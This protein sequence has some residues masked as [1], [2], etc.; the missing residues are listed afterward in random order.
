MCLLGFSTAFCFTW[1]F[2]HFFF[3]QYWVAGL[4]G[5]ISRWTLGWTGHVDKNSCQGICGQVMSSPAHPRLISS[6]AS[7]VL[8]GEVQEQPSLVEAGAQTCTS[9][10]T[11]QK[12]HQ[13]LSGSSTTQLQALPKIDAKSGSRHFVPWQLLDF[14][15]TFHFM[16]CLHISECLGCFCTRITHPYTQLCAEEHSLSSCSQTKLL[17]KT[18]LSGI[19]QK[20][21][22]STKKLTLQSLF[23]APWASEGLGYLSQCTE[24]TKINLKLFSIDPCLSYPPLKTVRQCLLQ[25]FVFR[26]EIYI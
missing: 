9:H 5:Q 19:R 2:C 26:L 15:K 20:T 7:H 16:F 14:I 21:K 11:L 6:G 23:S 17:K 18:K 22:V 10:S 3:F 8:G 4:P 13:I 24:V 25:P 1:I 12:W